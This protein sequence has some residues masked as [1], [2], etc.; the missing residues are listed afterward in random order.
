MSE[1][2]LKAFAGTVYGAPGAQQMLLDCQDRLG[3]DVLCLLGACWL[4]ATERSLDSA[5][6]RRVLAEHARWRDDV[7]EPLRRARRA[8]KPIQEAEGFYRQVKQC[9]LS[10]E[11]LA[12]EWLEPSLS[13]HAV[14]D[15]GQI[16][17]A[18]RRCINAYC[19]AAGVDPDILQEAR[20]ALVG[21]AVSWRAVP[22]APAD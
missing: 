1:V 17:A 14:L 15:P 5:D 10:A 22:D 2:S 16:E 7:I 11:W 19:E 4:G 18:T 8:I 12:L 6:W 13:A 21:L 20:T 3:L 9:E